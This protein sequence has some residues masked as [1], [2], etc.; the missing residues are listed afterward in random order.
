MNKKIDLL[1]K[2]VMILTMDSNRTFFNKGSIAIDNGKI[3]DVGE[4][5]TYEARKVISLKNGVAMPGLINCHTHETLTRG[6]CE[7]LK[8]MDWLERICFPLDASYTPEIIEASSRMNQLEMILSGTTTFIDIYRFPESAA[9]VIET[10][11]L[12]GFLSPQVIDI[13]EGVGETLEGN[14]ELFNKWHNK[15]DGRIKVWMG[16]HAPYSNTEKTYCLAKE[17]ADKHGIGVHTH[18]A[19]TKDE[20]NAYI[21][22]YN[23]TPIEFLY[24][25][26]ALGKNMIAAHCVHLTSKDIDILNKTGVTAVYNPTSNMK[27]ASGIAPINTLLNKGVKVALGTDSNLSNNNLDMFEEMKIAGL[28]QKL[29]NED[30]TV[31]PCYQI[32]EMATIKGAE[33]LGIGEEAGSIEKGKKADII[34]L[35]FNKPHLWPYF[36]GKINNIVEHIV[37][38]ANGADVDTTIVDGRVLMEGRKVNTIDKD[39][40]FNEVQYMSKYLCKRAKLMI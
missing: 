14:I 11:G 13:P 34:I 12:R 5:V 20:V 3:I 6:I 22:K 31:L 25:A 9:K 4:A 30:A 24:N 36:T 1:I 7:D 15:A 32:L 17:F 21:E 39:E 29:G 37:Y 19:E 28:L 23:M 35:D 27:L 2:D 38:S 18:L 10:S 8:L 16:I 33:A 26:K 40:V